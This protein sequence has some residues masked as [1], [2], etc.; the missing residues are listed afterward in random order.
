[1][2]EL[3]GKAPQSSNSAIGSGDNDVSS[4]TGKQPAA[5]LGHTSL[6]PKPGL[7]YVANNAAGRRDGPIRIENPL[8]KDEVKDPKTGRVLKPWEKPIKRAS[9]VAGS[10]PSTASLNSTQQPPLPSTTLQQQQNKVPPTQQPALAQTQSPWQQTTGPS[11]QMGYASGMSAP[12]IQGNFVGPPGGPP[13]MFGFP[14]A[15]AFGAPPPMFGV[16]AVPGGMMYP[17]MMQGYPPMHAP[18]ASSINN[19]VLNPPPPP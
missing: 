8:M 18:V 10:R 12:P 16:P 2:S 1:M 14:G 19:Q 3:D 7:G 9:L 15:P 5:S 4:T 17:P 6:G 13:P 11:P